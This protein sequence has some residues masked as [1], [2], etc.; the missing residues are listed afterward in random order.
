MLFVLIFTKINKQTNVLFL[1]PLRRGLAAG[2]DCGTPLTF[3][4]TVL[5]RLEKCFYF[6]IYFFFLLE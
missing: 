6:F 3:L 5:K 4:F 2:C 1:F